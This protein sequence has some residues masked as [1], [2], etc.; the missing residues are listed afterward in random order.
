VQSQLDAI[1]YAKAM[2]TPRAFHIQRIR[3]SRGFFAAMLKYRDML[4]NKKYGLLGQF[5]M[6]ISFTVP[7]ILI[8]VVSTI[9]YN[10]ALSAYRNIFFISTVGKDL[11][12]YL[13]NLTFENLLFTTNIQITLFTAA[14]AACGIVLMLKAHKHLKENLRYPFTALIFFTFYQFVLSAYWLIALCYELIGA[15]KV[16]RGVERW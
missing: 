1:V 6:P 16:W 11:F 2:R 14:V 9:I 10:T 3:W 5:M 8:A 13:P 4:F 7:W 15:K 12:A